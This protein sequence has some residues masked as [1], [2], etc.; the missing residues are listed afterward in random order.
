ML[1]VPR[2]ETRLDGNPAHP[3]ALPSV[4]QIDVFKER[5]VAATGW[6]LAIPV[7]PGAVPLDQLDDIE[8]Y[9][10]HWSFNRP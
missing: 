3:D 1:K 5:S 9:F 8:L 2:T 4:N 7:G 6:H 10:Y